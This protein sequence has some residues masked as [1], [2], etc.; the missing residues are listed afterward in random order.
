MNPLF[1]RKHTPGPWH[2]IPKPPAANIGSTLNGQRCYFHEI[3]APFVEDGLY[4]DHTHQIVMACDIGEKDARLIAKAP[5]LLAMLKSCLR[6]LYA[7][8]MTEDELG[9]IYSLVQEIEGPL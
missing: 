2:V 3:T 9:P 1:G 7:N 4:T 5:E 8:G 6:Q